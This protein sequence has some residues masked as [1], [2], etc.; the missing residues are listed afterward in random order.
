GMYLRLAFA[1]AAH[2]D[3]EILLVDEVLAVG[4][5]EFQRKCFTKIQEVGKLGRTILFV[6]HNMSAIRHICHTGMMLD[7]G[8]L[9]A[10]G[11]INVIGDQYM[12]TT[13]TLE[14]LSRGVETPSFLIEE[15][16]INPNA[17]SVAKTFEPFE[18]AVRVTAK[19][20]IGTPGLYIGILTSD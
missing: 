3:T 13:A 5:A 6:S 9:L 18:F 7:R 2:L 14:L 12:A 4:D 15:I 8:C 11:G 1:V 16:A 10:V 19:K 20:D 17:A